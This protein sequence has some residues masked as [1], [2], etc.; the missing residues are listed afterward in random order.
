MLPVAQFTEA[1]VAEAVRGM[2]ATVLKPRR[3]PKAVA[4]VKQ[5]KGFIKGSNGFAVGYPVK[6]FV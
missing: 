5:S 3:A 1:E 4:R 6:V 2:G